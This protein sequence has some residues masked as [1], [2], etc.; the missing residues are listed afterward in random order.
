M[1]TERQYKLYKFLKV[2]AKE[3]NFMPTF[4][5][6]QQHMNV[7]S[8]SGIFNLLF[9]MEWKGYIKRHPAHKRAIQIIKEYENDNT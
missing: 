4:R 8:K 5:E 7:K 3:N 1:L 9:Y 6:M 2:Y